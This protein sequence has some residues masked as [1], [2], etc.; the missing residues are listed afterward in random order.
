M[1]KIENLI[2]SVNDEVIIEKI[3]KGETIL[4][5]I[6]MRR[7]NGALYKI[8]KMYGFTSEDAEDIVQEV[9]IAA[10]NELPNFQYRS[11][12]KTWVSKIMINKCLYKIK[13][14]KF[15]EEF[16][17]ESMKETEKPVHITDVPSDKKIINQELL[18]IL[19][20]CVQRLPIDYRTV[21]VLREVQGYTIKETANLLEISNANVKIRLSRAKAL[22]RSEIEKFYTPSDLFDI[23]LDKCDEIVK[24]VFD[25]LKSVKSRESV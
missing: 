17:S 18:K 25:K 10:L 20:I 8:A 7:Y 9:H 19:E 24:E 15:K 22:L 5:E 3:K 2:G 14:G 4:F 12:Y 11:S 23:K 1:K 13:H 6:L 21:F 16:S